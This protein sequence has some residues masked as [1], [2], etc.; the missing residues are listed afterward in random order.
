MNADRLRRLLRLAP[1]CPCLRTSM[2][3]G[4][5]RRVTE[6]ARYQFV[7]LQGRLDKEFRGV[8]TSNGLTVSGISPV[9]SLPLMS[10]TVM[11]V[12]VKV[13]FLDFMFVILSLTMKLKLM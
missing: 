6:V 3:T 4:R 11:V 5:A 10:A 2:T 1:R 7:L 9:T 8:R 13:I 12:S